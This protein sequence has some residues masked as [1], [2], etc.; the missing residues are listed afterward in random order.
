MNTEPLEV[1]T[2]RLLIL[3]QILRTNLTI[4]QICEELQ[5]PKNTL[6][7]RM[8]KLRHALTLPWWWKRV[9][10][11]HPKFID[12]ATLCVDMEEE[13]QA[14]RIQICNE[15]EV[16]YNKIQK[17]YFGGATCHRKVV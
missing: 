12:I 9:H 7:A 1:L 5:I 3:C 16:I 8:G 4:N 15:R 17:D 14:I 2:P 10:Y 13:Q 6:N 11:K